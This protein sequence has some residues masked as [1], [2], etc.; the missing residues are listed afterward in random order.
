MGGMR[1]GSAGSAGGNLDLDLN[2]DGERRVEVRDIDGESGG[3]VDVV[4]EKDLEGIVDFAL[5]KEDDVDKVVAEEV[6]AVGILEGN[7]S[8]RVYSRDEMYDSMFGVVG[9]R[10]VG[11]EEEEDIVWQEEG[12]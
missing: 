10:K 11:V 4:E 9:L 5:D 2:L 12:K 3:I 6:E 1:R 8:I 7:D